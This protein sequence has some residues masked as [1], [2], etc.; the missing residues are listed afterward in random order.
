MATPFAHAFVA[1]TLGKCFYEGR[2]PV[3]FWLI[4]AF[5]ANAPDLDM[6]FYWFRLAPQSSLLGHRIFFHSISFAV[7]L[8]LLITII[9][10]REIKTYSK[11]WYK[12][13][14]FLTIATASHGILDALTYWGP[15]IAFFSP[16]DNTG[17]LCPCAPVPAT[18]PST[19]FTPR[20]IIHL[21]CEI[22]WFWGG[23]LVILAIVILFRKITRGRLQ[24]SI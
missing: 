15:G 1:C 14:I 4:S 10:F 3:K 11:P 13:W 6:I 7:L 21:A 12:T 16:F 5:C 18:G 17:Y 23:S 20:I 9:F 22:V 2:Q 8:G 24:K 19:F